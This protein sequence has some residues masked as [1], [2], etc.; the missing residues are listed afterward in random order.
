[1]GMLRNFLTVA[2]RS[3]VKQKIYS[4]IKIVGFAIGVAACII[5]GLFITQE[6]S[7]DNYYKAGDRI[8]RILRDA[9]FRDETGT[10][11]HFP[12]PYANAIRESFPEFEEVGRYSATE[13]FGAGSNEIRRTD[14][15][16]TT[17]EEGFI[18]MDQPMINILEVDFISGNHSRALR[19]PHTMLITKGKADKFFPNEDPLGKI[20]ILND[21]ENRQY[22]ITGV[23]QDPPVTSHL[24]YNFIM[25]LSGVE[26]YEGE[27]TNWQNSNYPTYVRVRSGTD[28]VA[29]EQKL[30]AMVKTYFLPFELN[31]GGDRESIKWLESMTFRLQPV[32]EIYLNT[33]GIKEGLAHGDVRY[34]WL[35][36]AIAFF[37]LIIA[38]VNFI[39]LSTAKSANR[40]KEIGLR[41]VVG[42][43]RNSLVKQFLIESSLFSLLS[44]AL[45]IL[46]AWMFLPYF[47][48]LV[49]KEIYF[50]WTD[51]RLFSI[52]FL[53]AIAVG[54]LAGI[55]PA[56]YLSSFRPVEVLKGK[57]SQGTR[58]SATRSGLVVFQFTVSIILISATFI[59]DR[60]MDFVLTRKL[61]FDKEKVLLILGAHT[62]G[63]RIGTFKKELQSL[64]VVKHVTV[65]GYIPVEGTKRNGNAF[66]NEGRKELDPPVGA[67]RWTVDHDYIK[68]MGLK[69]ID[70]R[71]FSEGIRSDSQAVVVNK[72]MASA[73]NLTQP[74]G[75][76]IYNGYSTWTIIGVVEDFH[77][78]TMKQR[79]EPLCLVMGNSQEIVS[80]KANSDDA[81]QLIRAV[82]EKWKTFSPNQP[83]RYTFLDQSYEHMYDDVR[84]MGQL[85]KSFAFLAVII[86]CLGLF[87]LS[88]FIA[89]QRSKEISIRLVLGASVNSILTLLSSNFLKLVLL[90]MVLATPVSLYLMREWL[91]EFAYKTDI[92]W[93]VFA[94]TALVSFT[95]AAATISYQSLRAAT[96]NPADNLRSD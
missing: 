70:G 33:E 4:I 26:F 25:T 41:K 56:F 66:F 50:P 73:L 29:L 18:Y 74:I 12:A 35:F 53:A 47:S 36:G 78:T 90:S 62:L 55:Y 15:L 76:R 22:T 32:N 77:F 95:V 93:E 45:G 17:H 83:I 28:I 72:A 20:L 46:I 61:G 34:T 30:R 49:A 11:V 7:Y 85:F 3:L 5:I 60:Q 91:N 87:A 81:Q 19:E 57:L 71:D 88:A 31:A 38:V 42:S 37:I 84:R 67:Q 39:N 24:Q 14:Y 23:I 21:D 40:A 68:T 75:K 6:L 96:V 16:E 89:E 65:T 94:L 27:Q 82:S 2:W 64:P 58:R 69:L 13:F 63:D 43:L 80:V 51:W 9:T 92:G 8:F 59:I 86:A 52:A 79:I 1:M 54:I 44:F 10:G 48:V